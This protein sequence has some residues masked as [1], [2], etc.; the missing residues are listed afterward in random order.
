MSQKKLCQARDLRR[1]YKIEN[2]SKEMKSDGYL[3]RRPVVYG[4][5][6]KVSSVDTECSH[7]EH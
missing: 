6:P 3:I 7:D 4:L 5:G 1:V 2:K